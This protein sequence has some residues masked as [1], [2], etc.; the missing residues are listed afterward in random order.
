MSA[1]GSPQDFDDLNAL[2]ESTDN[3]FDGPTVIRT[4]LDVKEDL[5]ST[6]PLS[7]NQ[8]QSIV[9]QS[10]KL[11]GDTQEEEENDPGNNENTGG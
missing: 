10:F 2:D 4:L 11:L 5:D 8:I 7:A 1:I 3:G 9:E 6:I